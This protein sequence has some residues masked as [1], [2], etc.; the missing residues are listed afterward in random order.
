MILSIIITGILIVSAI[1]FGV[2][3]Y[4][5][6]DAE[7]RKRLLVSLIFVYAIILMTFIA[8]NSRYSDFNGRYCFDN[9]TGSRVEYFRID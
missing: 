4:Y 1:V 3:L 6:K 9:W 2:I 5:T 8:H 7:K